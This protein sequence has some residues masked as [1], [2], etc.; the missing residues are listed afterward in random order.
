MRSCS[1]SSGASACSA[2]SHGRTP[3]QEL[4]LIAPYSCRACRTYLADKVQATISRIL[5]E[6]EL[7]ISD[8]DSGRDPEGIHYACRPK[9]APKKQPSRTIS[10]LLQEARA[11]GSS[12]GASSTDTGRT[13][14]SSTRD[15]DSLASS[16]GHQKEPSRESSVHS[17]PMSSGSGPAPDYSA[18]GTVDPLA[19]FG[20]QLSPLP[21]PSDGPASSAQPPASAP[22]VVMSDPAASSFDFATAAA[23]SNAF[24]G[25]SLTTLPVLAA[26]DK[27]MLCRAIRIR[28]DRFLWQ[29]KRQLHR[30][31]DD[32]DLWLVYLYRASHSISSPSELEPAQFFPD[33]I[34]ATVRNPAGLQRVRDQVEEMGGLLADPLSVLNADPDPL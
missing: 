17:A 15:S 31:G 10:Q 1:S 29:Y 20:R 18:P 8:F 26:A 30:R 24:W 32:A 12:S 9:A 34:V 22:T 13:G 33:R 11:A 2:A 23:D 14:T 5:T 27:R 21:I 3:F 25:E 19:F 7:K 28:S 4:Y 16:P 6:V